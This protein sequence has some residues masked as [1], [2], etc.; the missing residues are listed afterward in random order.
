M[1]R[2]FGTDGI[3]GI[4]NKDLTCELAT[5]LGRAAATVLTNKSTRHPRVIIGKDTR[6]SSYMFEY[7]LAGGIV[8]SGADAHLLHVF[9]YQLLNLL[10]VDDDAHIQILLCFLG[11]RHNMLPS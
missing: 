3:R 10:V 7:V 8:S 2:L 1:A 4:A 6:L 5:K 11:G 9:L